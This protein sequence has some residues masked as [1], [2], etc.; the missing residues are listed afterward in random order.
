MEEYGK[1]NESQPG[2]RYFNMLEVD[3]KTLEVGLQ[4]I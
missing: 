3:K 1:G 4:A 2:A